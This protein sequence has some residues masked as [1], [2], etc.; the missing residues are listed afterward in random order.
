MPE[1]EAPLDE[2][3]NDDGK[4]H[5]EQQENPRPMREL[6][7]PEQLTY[8]QKVKLGIKKAEAMKSN[9]ITTPGTMRMGSVTFEQVIKEQ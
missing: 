1:G 9:A 2:I 8:A 7:E 4:E 5:E 3:A 6:H